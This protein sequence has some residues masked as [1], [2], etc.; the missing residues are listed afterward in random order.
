MG[1]LSVGGE[2]IKKKTISFRGSVTE[3]GAGAI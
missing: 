2:G 3:I 1:I